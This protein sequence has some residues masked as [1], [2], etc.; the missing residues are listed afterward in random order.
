MKITGSQSTVIN[1]KAEVVSGFGYG[2][3]ADDDIVRFITVLLEVGL[4]L[5]FN[6]SEAID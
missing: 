6:F 5:L 3:G 4:H 2:F 1:G